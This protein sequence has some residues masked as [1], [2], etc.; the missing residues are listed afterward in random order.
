[1]Q[2]TDAPSVP[3]LVVAWEDVLTSPLDLC[4]DISDDQWHAPS[5]CPGWTVADVVAHMADVERFLAGLPS[6]EHTPDWDALPHVRGDVGRFTEVGVD[7]LRGAPRAEVLDRLREVAVVRRS[8][9]DALPP[10]AE[11]LSPFGRPTSLERLV[12]MR[13]F[14]LWA[15]EQDIRA[16]LQR[17]GG[18]GSDA[19]VVSFQQ[20]A[21]AMLAVWSS[22]D[23][24]A[25]AVVHLAVTGPGV[26]GDVWAATDG[27]GRGS[28]PEPGAD[29]TVE[30]EL[31][32]PDYAL[33]SCGRI[34]PAD[35]RV[36]LV[37]RGDEQLAERLLA[38]LAITP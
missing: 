7:A 38:E 21:K 16:G 19:A 13:T 26:E 35:V 17:D 3:E 4:A 25:G 6:P 34:T 30:I 31:S 28:V 2:P 10:D 15:H 12:R 24:P 29:A 23:A 14:D 1:M 37:V 22:I 20:I 9:L 33:L 11:V 32:W 27:A 36:P 18:W 5:L 8:Q